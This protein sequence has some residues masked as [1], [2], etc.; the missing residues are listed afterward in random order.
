MN[1]IQNMIQKGWQEKTG[2]TGIAGDWRSPKFDTGAGKCIYWNK[3]L[4]LL[5]LLLLLDIQ[6]YQQKWNLHVLRMPENRL[7]CKSLQYQPQG[8]R[9]LGRP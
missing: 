4:L 3:L 8:K 7:Q 9:D 1:D 2:K 6:N 5:L